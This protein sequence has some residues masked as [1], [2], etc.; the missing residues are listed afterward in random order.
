MARRKNVKRIDPRYFLNETVN[1]NDDG[2]AME[3][4]L[5]EGSRSELQARS[6][7]RQMAKKL[8]GLDKVW[9]Q[10]T[11]QKDRFERPMGHAWVERI[12]AAIKHEK[13][14]EAARKADFQK[15]MTSGPDQGAKAAK[16]AEFQKQ[17]RSGP[18]QGAKAAKQ[19]RP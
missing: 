4:G 13:G 17:M 18:D 9:Q 16:Q 2:S 3:A 19:V 7:V 15:Q 5:S 8:G 6:Y 1:R 11:Q 12:A 10:A 14:K